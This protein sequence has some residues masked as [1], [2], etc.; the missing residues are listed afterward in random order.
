MSPCAN[1]RGHISGGDIRI[2]SGRRRFRLRNRS[3]KSVCAC[4]PKEQRQAKDRSCCCCCC[5]ND[6]ISL[7][8]SNVKTHHIEIEALRGPFPFKRPLPPFSL[9]LTMP[10][11]LVRLDLKVISYIRQGNTIKEMIYQRQKPNKSHNKRHARLLRKVYP[12]LF[13][14]IVLSSISSSFV[15]LLFSFGGT[16]GLR[17]T[18]L[19]SG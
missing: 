2:S 12:F 17:Y 10:T 4:L 9:I 13:F 8:H 18:G 19:G 11:R 5:A 6:Y 16:N 7:H 1:R 14:S 15:I 3:E